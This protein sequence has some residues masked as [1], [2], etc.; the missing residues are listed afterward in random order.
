LES[1]RNADRAASIEGARPAGDLTRREMRHFSN[2]ELRTAHKRVADAS[3]QS[4][5]SI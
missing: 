3:E 2:G 5:T 4:P 1:R